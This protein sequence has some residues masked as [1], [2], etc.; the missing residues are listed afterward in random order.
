MQ[1]LLP[2]I[3]AILLLSYII[4]S[5]LLSILV[6]DY[7]KFNPVIHLLN[8]HANLTRHGK[9]S[10]IEYLVFCM[11]NVIGLLVNFCISYSQSS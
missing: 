3:L 4:P 7:H 5:I 6:Q 8:C 1:P 11:M 2:A 9:T 10:L